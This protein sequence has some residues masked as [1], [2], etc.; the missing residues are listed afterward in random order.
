MSR[1]GERHA[2]EI[3]RLERR[4]KELEDALGRLVRDEAEAQEVADLA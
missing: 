1:E 4:K 2:A 3:L